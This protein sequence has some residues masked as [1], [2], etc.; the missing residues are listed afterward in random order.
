MQRTFFLALSAVIAAGF[1]VFAVH[2][3]GDGSEPLDTHTERRISRYLRYN[4]CP[5]TYRNTSEGEAMRTR[6]EYLLAKRLEEREN[7]R[8]RRSHLGER[9][10]SARL[11]SPEV[12]PSL[13]AR[14][15]FDP[16][17]EGSEP[18]DSLQESRLRRYA[19]NDNCD[20]DALNDEE[21][22]RCIFLLRERDYIRDQAVA[23]GRETS[24]RSRMYRSPLT[25]AERRERA[26]NLTF[27]SARTDQRGFREAT[28]PMLPEFDFSGSGSTP[29][30]EA[31]ENRLY[32]YV[33]DDKCPKDAS[34]EITERCEYLLRY[35]RFLRA[36]EVMKARE[37]LSSRGLLVPVRRG[38]Q[39]EYRD[40]IRNVISIQGI[41]QS[42]GFRG[43]PRTLEEAEEDFGDP[44]TVPGD[45]QI[46]AKL[47][48]E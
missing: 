11:R 38:V 44:V 32:R 4:V 37:R 29:L 45:C 16:Q 8:Q 15:P 7:I 40:L 34:K 42:T 43:R 5:R 19:Q 36:S 20:V 10:V 33:E 47:C 31:Q 2:A 46:D 12:K 41:R 6:C 18:L 35:R 14:A 3:Q 17:G 23:R 48:N 21:Q 13:A 28:Q 25:A 30:G 24:R 9:D 22:T 27:M 26:K 1:S 39:T